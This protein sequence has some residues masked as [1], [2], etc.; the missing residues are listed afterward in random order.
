LAGPSHIEEVKDPHSSKEVKALVEQD[1]LKGAASDVS[2]PAG[3]SHAG[4]P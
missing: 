1:G 2:D 4:L 3:K